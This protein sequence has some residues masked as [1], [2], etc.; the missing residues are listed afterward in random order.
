MANTA[1]QKKLYWFYYII[2]KDPNHPELQE[3]RVNKIKRMAKRN[4]LICRVQKVEDIV[5][6]WVQTY[7]KFKAIIIKLIAGQANYHYN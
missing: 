3:T 2:P 6:I 4:K 7:E 1:G 5:T